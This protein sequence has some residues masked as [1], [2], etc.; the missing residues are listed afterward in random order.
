VRAVRQAMAYA[1]DR[2]RVATIG[3]YGYEPVGNQTG[4]I[5]PNF[6]R[7]YDQGQAARYNYTYNP[8]KAIALL[9]N[10]G[11]KRNKAGIF[12][13]PAGKP[14]SFSVINNAGYT[15]S[16]FAVFGGD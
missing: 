8:Q 16:T 1:I 13:T 11:F 5:L 4:V 6:R 14:L 12:Q 3:E 9:Q 7:W 2:Q 15:D 10:A